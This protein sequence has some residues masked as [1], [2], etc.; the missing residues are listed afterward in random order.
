MPIANWSSI[1]PWPM[2]ASVSKKSPAAWP[3]P[4]EGR[5][6]RQRLADTAGRGSGPE[7]G[8]EPVAIASDP[9][10]Q[11]QH[12]NDDDDQTEST[13]RPVAPASTVT[14]RRQ[15][16]DQQHDE[17]DQQNGRQSHGCSP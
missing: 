14:P 2:H 9:A 13:A 5:T 1:P 7:T 12:E 3:E 16:A 8:S 10:H 17:H 4:P 11:K 6:D 15:R